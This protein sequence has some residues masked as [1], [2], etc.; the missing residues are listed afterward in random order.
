VRASRSR[1]S[2]IALGDHLIS[3][4]L[5]ED[6]LKLLLWVATIAIAQQL[7]DVLDLAPIAQKTGL[8]LAEL[9]SLKPIS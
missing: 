6:I 5:L 3:G 9:R 4:N 7:L 1:F 8:S 2:E